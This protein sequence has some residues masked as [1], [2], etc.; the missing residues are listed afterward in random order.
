[1]AEL[2]ETAAALVRRRISLGDRAQALVRR[3]GSAFFCDFD[4]AQTGLDWSEAARWQDADSNYR[5]FLRD[6]GIEEHSLLGML[7]FFDG[8]YAVQMAKGGAVARL[9][10]EL[11][12]RQRLHLDAARKR[13]RK[14]TV[15]G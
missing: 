14:Y 2:Q 15:R 1:L 8:E 7:E 4:H 12:E 9:Y 6:Q 5:C 13:F 3:D 11:R 10:G